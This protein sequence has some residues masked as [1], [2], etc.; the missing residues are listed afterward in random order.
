MSTCAAAI[1]EDCITELQQIQQD[2]RDAAWRD[3]RHAF[4]PIYLAHERK[5]AA[6]IDIFA[7]WRAIE[8]LLRRLR[9]LRPLILGEESLH[10]GFKSLASHTGVV[11][12][13]DAL[14]GTRLLEHGW[15]DWC[16]AVTVM[17]PSTAELICSVVLFPSGVA[18]FATDRGA[19]K[20]RRGPSGR[21]FARVSGPSDVAS[22]H[23]ATVA[24]YGYRRRRFA[25]LQQSVARLVARPSG[26]DPQMFV[27]GGNPAL[28]HVI[29]G[30]RRVDAVIEPIGQA[31]HDMLAGAHICRQ[32]GA[33]VMELDGTVLDLEGLLW[34][35]PTARVK[36]VAAGTAA[37]A[38]ELR[39]ELTN[40]VADDGPALTLAGP[41]SKMGSTH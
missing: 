13:L 20:C 2:V 24:F 11:V 1:V 28:V 32:A 29:D 4:E 10:Y 12:L 18:Y 17:R 6:V 9:S 5:H 27:V 22:C 41:P 37:L 40:D 19:G 33:T 30:H 25:A 14:D 21:E 3:P 16:S 36:Y 39:Q 8:A 23:D 38:S 35:G 7:E 34:R 26:A 15:S 31:P